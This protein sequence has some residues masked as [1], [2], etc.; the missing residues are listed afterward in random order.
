MTE[1]TALS[2][3]QL[4][5]K[6]HKSS[7]RCCVKYCDKSYS[8]VVSLFKFP[9]KVTQKAVFDQWVRFVEATHDPSSWSRRSSPVHMCCD[10]FVSDKD[11]DNFM[12]FREVYHT[13]Y[14]K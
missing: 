14:C 7:K 6:S 5:S 9:D 13:I 4:S 10:Q 2:D 12:Q 8:E 1:S 3:S 11:F